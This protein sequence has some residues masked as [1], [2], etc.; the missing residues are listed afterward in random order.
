MIS[1][2]MSV[3]LCLQGY[4]SFT[5][6][7]ETVSVEAIVSSRCHKGRDIGIQAIGSDEAL[8][9]ARDDAVCDV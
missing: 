2:A 4:L 5:C 3:R 9:M 7:A 1:E 8:P 6:T